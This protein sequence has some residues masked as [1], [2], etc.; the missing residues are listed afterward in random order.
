MY[1]ELT[2]CL[3]THPYADKG[4][5]YRWPPKDP[6]RQIPSSVSH[7]WHSPAAATSH[8]PRPPPSGDTTSPFPYGNN[9]FNPALVAHNTS[10]RNRHTPSSVSNSDDS[11]SS[12]S[13]GS[14]DD[15]DVHFPEHQPSSAYTPNAHA[16]EESGENDDDVADIVTSSVRIR[17]GSEG[18]EVRPRAWVL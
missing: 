1:T 10:L 17:R 11:S 15:L 2:P 5:Q 6:S 14:D 3:F 8:H 13:S 16:Y 18:Y 4:A 9:G 12:I 7:P